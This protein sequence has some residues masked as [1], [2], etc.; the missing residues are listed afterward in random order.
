MKNN[1]MSIALISYK[2]IYSVKLNILNPHYD[3]SA[4]GRLF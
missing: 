3:V 4:R 1:V 2:Y